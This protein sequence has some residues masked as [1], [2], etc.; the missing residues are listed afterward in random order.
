MIKDKPLFGHG[1]EK[2]QANY[3]D[4]Q[5]SYFEGDPENEE[6]YVADDIIY[7]FNEYIKLGVESGILEI[8]LI[9]AN[10]FFAFLPG[11]NEQRDTNSFALKAGILGLMIFAFFSY[12]GE[13]LSMII[14]LTIL[15]AL[16][17]REKGIILH[18]RIIPE[19][20][21][22]RRHGILK[23]SFSITLIILVFGM[24]FPYKRLYQA[25]FLWDEGYKIY[26][27]NAYDECLESFEESY[28]VLKN[29]GEFLIMY[30]KA[31]SMA[32]KNEE[33]VEVL[34]QAKNYHKNTILYT[35]MGDSYKD[36]GQIEKAESA[37]SKAFI[38]IPSRFYPKYLLAKLYEETDQYEKARIIANEIL[39]KK[40]KI[41]S[42]AIEE[43]KE[44]MAEILEK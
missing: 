12:P 10:L 36:L 16:L 44:E 15:L 21:G 32:E 22:I 41:P 30:G 28:D 23:C 6:S 37:Y 25:Y 31:L 13:I 27:M 18:K 14:T 1:Y 42:T 38:M 3:M 29:N 43:I 34:Q 5:A 24:Y 17:A 11:E 26:Q 20:S 39:S 35:A 19:Q 40:E 2:F 4:Y 7:P 8:C 33:T 9:M